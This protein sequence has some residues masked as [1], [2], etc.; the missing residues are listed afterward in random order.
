[1]KEAL[2]QSKDCGRVSF[3]G[4]EDSQDYVSFVPSVAPRSDSTGT[5]NTLRVPVSEGVS[6][7]AKKLRG[8]FERQKER[9]VFRI[10]IRFFA[11]SR[12]KIGSTYQSPQR[13]KSSESSIS[14]VNRQRRH[15]GPEPSPKGMKS[16][17]N[18]LTAVHPYRTSIAP[19]PAMAGILQNQGG[20]KSDARNCMVGLVCEWL[21]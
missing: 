18:P 16:R 6:V 10:R 12:K 9:K 14:S 7:D 15:A 1:M 2:R 17:S 5:Q 21:F 13:L 3:C 20:V 8:L 4:F 11:H 19:A